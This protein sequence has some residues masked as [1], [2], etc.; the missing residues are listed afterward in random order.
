MSQSPPLIKLA[1][2][3]VGANKAFTVAGQSVLI[4]HSTAGVFAV[5]NK[6]THQLAP[7]EGGRIRGP[8]LFCPKHGQR[9]DLRDGST[10]GPLS[11][12][13]LTTYPVTQDEEGSLCVTVA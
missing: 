13:A 6:C 4:C 3:P 10:G 12:I 8:H 5:E 11:K 7:L 9:F 1:D 2:L